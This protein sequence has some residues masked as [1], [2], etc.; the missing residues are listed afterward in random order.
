M[1]NTGIDYVDVA[2]GAQNGFATFGT[3]N[4]HN[5]TNGQ[6][7]YKNNEVVED[8]AYRALHTGAIVGKEITT[9]F[10]NKNYTKSYYIGCSTGGREGFKEA[11][12]FP[13]D[14][15]GII[16][17]APAI[18]FNHLNAWSNHFYPLLGPVNST[19]FPPVSMWPFIHQEILKQC[20]ALDGALDG[21]IEDP[22]LCY[23]RP[24]A[25][26]CAAGK[27]TNCLTGAQ[28][29][30]VRQVY[31]PLYGLNGTLIYPRMQP[32]AELISAGVYYS[33]VPLPYGVVS[34][35]ASH[36]ARDRH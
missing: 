10:Y 17:G 4:G 21:I 7:F 26:I 1:S 32:G 11:Q 2:Y 29:A 14:F 3:N 16:A 33:G 13:T 9:A 24:E 28:A 5:G 23:F 27:T 18:D 8:F 35:S 20:D 34:Y 36:S 12:S 19:G 25:L 6:A 30:T 22:E 31:E 15:D